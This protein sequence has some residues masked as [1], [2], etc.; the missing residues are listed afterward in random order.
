LYYGAQAMRRLLDARERISY[1]DFAT[2]VKKLTATSAR[3][4]DNLKR[5][6]RELVSAE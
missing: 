3:E 5:C 1:D 6:V 2:A 4:Q